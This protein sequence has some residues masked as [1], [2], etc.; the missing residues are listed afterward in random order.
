M[1]HDLSLSK[2]LISF[3]LNF[4]CN[5][6][7]YDLMATIPWVFT[8]QEYPMLNRF[9]FIGERSHSVVLTTNYC[10]CLH[11]SRLLGYI[12]FHRFE[13]IISIAVERPW[14]NTSTCQ[15]GNPLTSVLASFF[16]SSHAS[17]TS[18]SNLEIEVMRKSRTLSLADSDAKKVLPSA[19]QKSSSNCINTS[20][21]VIE[22]YSQFRHLFAPKH[23]LQK[24]SPHSSHTNSQSS[25]CSHPFA[26]R[27]LKSGS[28]VFSFGDILT[29]FLT[30]FFIY[31]DLIRLI[32]SSI[33]FLYML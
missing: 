6:A 18:S 7:L 24:L 4:K 16:S 1:S 3:H 19:F 29:F 27:K 21:V 10:P 31:L 30:F 22:G 23:S 8:I 33:S 14:L 12:F 5:G 25:S 11:P 20:F 32:A 13:F 2:G 17:T 9:I 28:A 15:I 26:F